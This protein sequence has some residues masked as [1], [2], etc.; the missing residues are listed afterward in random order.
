MNRKQLQNNKKSSTKKINKDNIKSIKEIVND[1]ENTPTLLNTHIL[2]FVVVV[3]YFL[4]STCI[5]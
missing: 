1:D 5:M 2:L 3:I 4:L